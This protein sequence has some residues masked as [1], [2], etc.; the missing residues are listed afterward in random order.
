MPPGNEARSSAL[1]TDF[2]STAGSINDGNDALLLAC[3]FCKSSMKKA[4]WDRVAVRNQHEDLDHRDGSIGRTD[5]ST[6]SR[7]RPSG[8]ACDTRCGAGGQAEGLRTAGD[9]D[10]KCR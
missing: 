5:R 6:P 10:G 9:G 3:G 4:L 7:S 8:L 1:L 2:F